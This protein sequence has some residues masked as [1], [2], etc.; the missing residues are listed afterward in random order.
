MKVPSAPPCTPR[1]IVF[2]GKYYFSLMLF[3]IRG[4]YFCDYPLD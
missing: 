4:Q 2:L 1:E 3:K